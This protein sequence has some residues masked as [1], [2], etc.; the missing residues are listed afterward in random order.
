MIL[1]FDKVDRHIS[2]NECQPQLSSRVGL[3]DHAGLKVTCQQYP[4]ELLE[5]WSRAEVKAM[6]SRAQCKQIQANSFGKRLGQGELGDVYDLNRK[7]NRDQIVNCCIVGHSQHWEASEWGVLLM[8]MIV[9]FLPALLG[10]H[11]IHTDEWKLYR[12]IHWFMW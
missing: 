1:I 9:L 2:E 7:A 11:N 10:I 3:G 4:C 12:W 6:A 8:S 5:L